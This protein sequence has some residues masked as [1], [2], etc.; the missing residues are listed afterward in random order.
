MSIMYNR[1]YWSL[2]LQMHLTMQPNILPRP[3]FY[4]P[5]MYL[6]MYKMLLTYLMHNVCITEYFLQLILHNSST[7]SV[8]Q[9]ICSVLLKLLWFKFRFLISNMRSMHLSLRF[10]QWFS[11]CMCHLCYGLSDYKWF[12]Y[13]C[14]RMPSILL[15]E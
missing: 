10:L 9:Q 6:S 2:H 15:P 1:L 12:S 13:M 3:K 5:I 11:C 14:S 7:M 4:M 8:P